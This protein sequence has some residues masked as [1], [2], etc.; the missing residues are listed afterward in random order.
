MLAEHPGQ[1][2]SSTP[3]TASYSVQNHT[4]HPA[5]CRNVMKPAANPLPGCPSLAT[6]SYGEREMV[7]FAAMMD[8][9][10]APLELRVL[11]YINHVLYSSSG[12]ADI[13]Q[14]LLARRL[15]STIPRISAAVATLEAHGYIQVD[16]CDR[17]R[18]YGLI[19]QDVVRAVEDQQVPEPVTMEEERLPVPVTIEAAC[20]PVPVTVEAQHLPAPVTR[21]FNTG[22]VNPETREET[23]SSSPPPGGKPPKAK[24]AEPEVP[25]PD[26][27]Q[28]SDALVAT[29]VA[30]YK[31]SEAEIRRHTLDFIDYFDG[32]KTRRTLRGW[33]GSWR[34]W[35]RTSA[36]GGTHYKP[37][38]VAPAT[39]LVRAGNLGLARPLTSEEMRRRR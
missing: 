39:D 38:K 22:T 30:A 35:M 8:Q 11:I 10:I 4:N 16:R 29:A 7:V 25:L 14:A 12:R 18:K 15:K 2:E 3:R 36:P 37:V 23:P 34:R 27:W 20:L 24:R 31:V 32:G 9:D 1:L 26:G 33:E 19:R 17:Q 21:T 5:G 6:L 13:G 28:P